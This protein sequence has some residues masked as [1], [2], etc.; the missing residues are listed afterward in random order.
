[1]FFLGAPRLGYRIWKDHSLNIST[2][3]A[4]KK[5]LVIGAGR[6]AEMLIRE[7]MREGSYMPV[8]LLDNNARSPKYDPAP[9]R[10]TSFAFS[11]LPGST[12][13]FTLPF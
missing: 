2:V 11:P 12:T 8:G 9:K 3:S 1:M 6:A 5:V 10:N 4:N 7:I 13:H